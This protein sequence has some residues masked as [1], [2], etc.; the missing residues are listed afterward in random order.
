MTTKF[1]EIIETIGTIKKKESL[2][3][4]NSDD[5]VLESLHP[6][7]GY[8][9]TTVPDK[10]NPK[11]IF[12]VLRSNFTEEDIIRAILRIKEKFHTYFDAAPGK[13][14][15]FNRMKTCIRIKDLE[16]YIF[17]PELLSHFKSEGFLFMKG[18]KIDA[19]EGLISIKKYFHLDEINDGVYMDKETHEMGYFEIST[20]LDWN[21]FEKITLDIK[22]NIEDNNF[23][24][25]L[26][27][28]YRKTGLK[29]II[30]IF[31][32]NICLGECLFLREKYISA[33]ENHLKNK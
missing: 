32:T 7:P 8:H 31:D 14:S 5:L 29:D 24:A 6:F 18:R 23:D 25:A 27:S 4:I 2:V 26:G 1:N 33:I 20:Q 12:F 22:R 13:I 19:Y 11:S 28:I 15:I 30:R 17:V 9:G 21:T 3:T 10:T 16:H